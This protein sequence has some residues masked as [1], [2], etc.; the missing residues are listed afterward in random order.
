MNNTS[1]INS[2]SQ[3]F[4]S[5]AIGPQVDSLSEP[6]VVGKGFPKV[7]RDAWKERIEN[8]RGSLES[9]PLLVESLVNKIDQLFTDDSKPLNQSDS[10]PELTDYKNLMTENGKREFLIHFMASVNILDLDLLNKCLITER[11]SEM[12]TV[13]G[14]E[15]FSNN[16]KV[17]QKS[18]KKDDEKN[19]EGECMS[20]YRQA[21][22]EQSLSNLFQQPGIT[23]ISGDIDDLERAAVEG[24]AILKYQITTGTP[25]SLDLMNSSFGSKY[26]DVSAM[27]EF[28][29]SFVHT[30]KFI[31]AP[32]DLVKFKTDA[33]KALKEC[34]AEDVSSDLKKKLA[35]AGDEGK[36][37]LQGA[38]KALEKH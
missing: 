35:D 1:A 3:M 10:V 19:T 22:F 23:I 37:K 29:T 7:I 30:N 8:I 2:T 4:S 31:E 9:N 18:S 14:K 33:E 34:L 16:R 25:M 21:L 17:L 24:F 27:A 20:K 6:R 26:N 28:I 5:F 15:E 32:D 12:E 13:A 38:E 36:R 11:H